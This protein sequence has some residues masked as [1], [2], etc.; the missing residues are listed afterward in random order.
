MASWDYKYKALRIRSLEEELKEAFDTLVTLDE[1]NPNKAV[2]REMFSHKQSE[3]RRLAGYFYLPYKVT[4]E[5]RR[6][7]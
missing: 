4:E 2:I 1:A 7:N 3:Y 6:K 5:E